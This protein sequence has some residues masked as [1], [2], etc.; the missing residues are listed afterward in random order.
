MQSLRAGLA[1]AILAAAP[2]WAQD[3]LVK[4]ARAAMKSADGADV[5]TLVLN[6][7]PAGVMIQGE[8]Q[9][10]PAGPHGFHVHE[11]G[12]CEPPFESA[13]GHY[14]PAGAEH[15]FLAEAGPHA[16]DMTNINVEADGVTIELLNTF[17]TLGP[18]LF[19][20]DGAA[21]LVHAMPDDYRS[22]PSG[23]AGDRIACGVIE[24]D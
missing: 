3:D 7:T 6:T 9:G 15:G 10:L 4:T 20:E 23:H 22:Q 1:L 19:D 16:G 11:T 12:A 2:A 21:I 24:A 17:L 8:L 14:D 18:E 13:G 5:G